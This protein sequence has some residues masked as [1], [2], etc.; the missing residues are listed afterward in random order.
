MCALA[1]GEEVR[2]A[3]DER[4]SPTYV[5]DLVKVCLDLLIDAESGIWHLANVG[6]V[7][8]AEFAER[9]ALMPS[10]DD[11][12]QRFMSAVR[13]QRPTVDDKALH[14]AVSAGH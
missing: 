11:A 6:D 3:D 14:A 4:I 10:I 1:A 13:E 7:S 9:A 8:W 5:P 2:I 12:L